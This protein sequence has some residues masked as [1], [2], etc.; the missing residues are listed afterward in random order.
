[1]G[2]RTARFASHEGNIAFLAL[3]V[4]LPSIEDG[5]RLGRERSLRT[6]DALV[7]SAAIAQG[8]KWATRER[9]PDGSDT[10]SFPSGHATGAFAVAAMQAR[11]H[12]DRAA[13]WYAGAALIGE[14]RVRLRR[15]HTHDVIAGAALGV[16]TAAVER[17]Q[18]RGLL[19]APFI[20]P[21]LSDGGGVR[22]GVG[23]AF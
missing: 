18:R 12:P 23:G 9:R 10:E 20:A 3:G 22:F 7:T 6:L 11:W 4:L 21:S 14:S 5:G 19:L 8:L 1:M 15:H 13:L 17:R 2:E 16:T